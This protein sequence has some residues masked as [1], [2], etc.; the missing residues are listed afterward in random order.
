MRESG[1]G[2]NL[3][4]FGGKGPRTG[5]IGD[6]KYKRI[7]H[8]RIPNADIYQMLAYLTASGLPEGMLIYAKGMREDTS[9]PAEEITYTVRMSG[10]S[11]HV[12]ALDLSGSLDEILERVRGL[13]DRIKGL[14]GMS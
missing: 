4:W 8:E 3:T 5:F 7:K 2:L 12:V 9:L 13:G 14:A 11:I 1:S 6:A 10:Q